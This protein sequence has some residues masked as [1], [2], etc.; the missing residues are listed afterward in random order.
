[1][2]EKIASDTIQLTETVARTTDNTKF[3]QANASITKRD[4]LA[5][6]RH[7]LQWDL[8]RQNSLLTSPLD[9][10]TQLLKVVCLILTSVLNIVRTVL[11]QLGL[12][13]TLSGLYHQLKL[14]EILYFDAV[15]NL[16]TLSFT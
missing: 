15:V 12:G 14:D 11:N 7:A 2:L 9:S 4:T 10:I 8:L 16:D 1:M 13:G 5:T 6:T 3:K